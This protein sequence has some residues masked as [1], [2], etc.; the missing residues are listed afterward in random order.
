MPDD[1]MPVSLNLK[2]N[3]KPYSLTVEPRKLLVE[4]LR[5]DLDLTGTHVG[6]D[7]SYCGACTVLMNGRAV[8]SCT[9]FAVQAD[10]A[11][12]VTVEGTAR[13]HPEGFRGRLRPAVRVLHAG[14]VAGRLPVVVHEPEAER[15]RNLPSH[16]RKHLPLHRLPECSQGNPAGC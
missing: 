3:G 15:E 2:V 5:E 12:I 9:V 4:L 13:S 7:S 8:K 14:P 10:G 1:A 16:R 6:C 11:E